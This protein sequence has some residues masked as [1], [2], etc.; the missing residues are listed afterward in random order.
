MEMEQMMAR[1]LAEIKTDISM[2]QA[3]MDATIRELRAGQEFLKEEMLVKLGVHYGRIMARV[4][5]QVEKMEAMDLE[6]DPE[7]IEFGQSLRRSLR[8]RP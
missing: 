1:L 4:N 7:E 6:E 8:K 3:K 5:S 2:N